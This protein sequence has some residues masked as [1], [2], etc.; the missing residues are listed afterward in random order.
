MLERIR[1]IKGRRSDK[2]LV[3]MRETPKKQ[4]KNVGFFKR[5]LGNRKKEALG[6]MDILIYT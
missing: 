5:L 2:S 6:I 1:R 3:T 4:L